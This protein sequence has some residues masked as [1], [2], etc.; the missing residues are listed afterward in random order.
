[1]GDAAKNLLAMKSA[2]AK[3]KDKGATDAFNSIC[4]TVRTLKSGVKDGA[5]DPFKMLV[6]IAS[7]VNDASI[8]E[9]PINQFFSGKSHAEGLKA[10]NKYQEDRA[11][12]RR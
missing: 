11:T 9:I 12:A 6:N 5:V 8:E 2:I 10:Y 1:V 3:S 4:K 7:G